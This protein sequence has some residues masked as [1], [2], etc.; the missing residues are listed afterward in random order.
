MTYAIPPCLS[1]SLELALSRLSTEP[2]DSQLNEF[3]DTYGTHAIRKVN[4]GAK[5]VTTATF[6]KKEAK[7]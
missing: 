7:Q 6:D 3:I 5:F 2:D 4:M 1:Q